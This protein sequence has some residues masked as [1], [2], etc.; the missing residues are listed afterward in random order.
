[1]WRPPLRG[2]QHALD[3]GLGII[4]VKNVI[5]AARYQFYLSNSLC[6]LNRP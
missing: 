5:F 6:N 4:H 3:A 2:V 1:V